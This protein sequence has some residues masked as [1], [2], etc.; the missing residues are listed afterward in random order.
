MNQLKK[1]FNNFLSPK[2]SEKII[3]YDKT[4]KIKNFL[5]SLYQACEILHIK[6]SKIS[7]KFSKTKKVQK[8][9]VVIHQNE[10]NIDLKIRLIARLKLV[11]PENLFVMR[12]QNNNNKTKDDYYK[13]L[14]SLGFK[15][16]VYIQSNDIFYFFYKYDISSYKKIHD[17]LNSDNWAN[18]EL[19]SK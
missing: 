2:K 10:K 17:W 15:F 19:W 3:I 12:L 4:K 6:N 11:S 5:S 1:T 14:I 9:I 13:L 7:Q 16:H 18:P 8:I